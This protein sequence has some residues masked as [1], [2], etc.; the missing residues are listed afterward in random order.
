MKWARSTKTD[1]ALT[2]QD[3]QAQ[4]ESAEREL[5]DWRARRDDVTGRLTTARGR[6]E[7][8][9][10]QAAAATLEGTDP[11]GV[12]R[13]RAAVLAEIEELELAL[14]MAAEKVATLEADLHRADRA[15]KIVA[16]F[17][18][19]DA[20]IA[21]AERVDAAWAPLRDLIGE[22]I[23]ANRDTGQALDKLL[24]SSWRRHTKDDEELTRVM[25]WPLQGLLRVAA[26][27]S[28]NE[29]VPLAVF[30]SY[31]HSRAVLE[32]ELTGEK[33]NAS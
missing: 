25:L 30:L 4:K 22:L 17:E 2:V 5:T 10:V 7:G 18:M 28:S 26:V 16:A 20:Q 1:G 13:E 21:L 3:A 15:V 23:L 14:G 32:R 12:R 29:R 24:P 11:K 33:E 8:L 19:L 9:A 6:A 31:S 27:L